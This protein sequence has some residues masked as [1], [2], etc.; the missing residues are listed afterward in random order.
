MR[1]AR[2]ILQPTVRNFHGTKPGQ[3]VLSSVGALGVVG[4]MV[5]P[6]IPGGTAIIEQHLAKDEHKVLAWIAGITVFGTM[7]SMGG[8]KDPKEAT[9]E[10]SEDDMEEFFAALEGRIV[11]KTIDSIVKGSKERTWLDKLPSVF[12]EAAARP[13]AEPEVELAKTNANL[14]SAKPAE[15]RPPKLIIAMG[16]AGTG[17]STKM[18]E[19]FR[20]FGIEDPKKVAISDGDDVRDCHVGIQAALSLDKKTL[21]DG[22]AGAE[23]AEYTKLLE[24]QPDGR[25]VGFKDCEKWVYGNSG[26]IK[27]QICNEAVEH[28]KDCLLAMTAMKP[29]HVKV[30]EAAVAEGYQVYVAGFVVKPTV[31]LARQIGRAQKTARLITIDK[32]IT[33]GNLNNNTKVKQEKAI[34][35]FLKCAVFAESTGGYAILF[36]NTPDFRLEKPLPPVYERDASKPATYNF[37]GFEAPT[38]VGGLNDYLKNFS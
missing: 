33:D 14:Y 37:Q 32:S 7:A 30:V 15:G 16:A 12:F 22:L 38:T 17:K 29:Q 2:A 6:A 5:A 18:D 20:K 19:C 23:K 1:G 31:L 26:A 21:V 10:S 28:R 24:S 11:I 3:G 13:L 27:S 9:E 8:S 35:G 34:K 25:P 36:D 4:V